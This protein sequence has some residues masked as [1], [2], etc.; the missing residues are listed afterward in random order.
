MRGVWGFWGFM[1]IW[2]CAGGQALAHEVW[3]DVPRLGEAGRPGPFCLTT[4][5]TNSINGKGEHIAKVSGAIAI[6]ETAATALV[7]R[8]VRASLKA[9]KKHFVAVPVLGRTSA[10]TVWGKACGVAFVADTRFLACSD[11]PVHAQD[12]LVDVLI[13]PRS[14][15]TLDLVNVYGFTPQEG[16]LNLTEALLEIAVARQNARGL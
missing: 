6:Q 7:V 16:H 13:W 4:I 9:A 1:L 10:T 12:R 11:M 15:V 14:D 8:T 5:N 3:T 2:L